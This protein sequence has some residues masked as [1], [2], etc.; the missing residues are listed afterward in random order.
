MPS[1]SIE[2]V[3][4]CKNLP[5]LPSVAV[6]VLA[7]TRDPN[8]PLDRI[9]KVIQN[10]AAI[11]AKVLKTVNSSYYGLAQRCATLNKAVGYLGIKTVKSLVLG[12]SL[13][14]TT[15]SLEAGGFNLA[16]YW[17]RGI[18]AATAARLLAGSTGATDP[19]EAFTACLFQ[20]IGMLASYAALGPDY[21]AVLAAA[22]TG[23]GNLSCV[24]SHEMGFSH[25]EVGARLAEKWNLP[26]QHVQAIRWHHD[27]DGAE[28]PFRDFVRIVA[29]SNFAADA[30]IQEIAGQSIAQLIVKANEWFGRGPDDVKGLLERVADSAKQLA[31][32]FGKDPGEKYN[33]GRIMS[34]ANE[35]LLET[36]LQGQQEAVTL[37]KSAAELAEA[38]V[39]D[40]LTGARNRK[41]F[42]AELPRCFHKAVAS[43]APLSVLFIDGDRFKNVND[44]HG[45]AAGD[46]VLREL[47]RRFISSAPGGA[48]VCRYGGEE[49]AVILP[50][51]GTDQAADAAETI[52]AHVAA[53]PFD[54]T[55]VGAKTDSV[56]VTIS[57]GVACMDPAGAGPIDTPEKLTHAAD[58]AVY[59]AKANGRNRVERA[60]APADAPEVAADV[61]PVASSAVPA[62]VVPQSVPAS[63]PPTPAAQ[64]AALAAPGTATGS[65][66]IL[67]VEHD[68]L[69]GRL[70]LTLLNKRPNTSVRLVRSAEEAIPVISGPTPPRLVVTDDRLGGMTGVQLVACA[71]ANPRTRALPFVVLS[72]RAEPQAEQECLRAGANLYLSK[73]AIINDV[74]RSIAAI[75]AQAA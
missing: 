20:D 37:K 38:A 34:E 32:E 53:S 24:E 56:R 71:R 31:K 59:A 8:V 67:L 19:D 72:A 47:A 74:N 44:T 29:L 36:S 15:K 27:P 13:V 46:A 21:D 45:H 30:G 1:V 33:V 10:D 9:A 2:Q 68:P 65:T 52:R 39:T 14:D 3:L 17:R 41:H 12:F 4:E 60:D 73:E 28:P 22:P 58:Q 42:D 69:A 57:V 62:P 51:F 63:R 16:D 40:A 7:L 43:G 70:L 6:E 54:L 35:L 48:V 5:S 64:P 75:L 49:F 26:G 66:S 18:Y 23:H 61:P 55:G 50:G 25:N 11:T